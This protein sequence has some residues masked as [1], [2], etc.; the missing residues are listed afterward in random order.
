MKSFKLKEGH[1]AI[2]YF[3]DSQLKNISDF[4]QIMEDSNL[5]FIHQ[6]HVPKSKFTYKQNTTKE[7]TVEGDSLYIFRKNS[8]I[9]EYPMG[10]LSENEI[11]ELIL[12]LIDDYLKSFGPATAS[13]IMDNCIVPNLW[14]MKLLHKIDSGNFYQK[15][16][17]ESFS[18][19][20]ETRKLSVRK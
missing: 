3:K 11:S 13:T 4:L 7:G 16:I 17:V 5:E 19:D 15:L 1:L 10:D 18:I 14:K 9:P 2:I 6:I 8:N 20:K 12:N